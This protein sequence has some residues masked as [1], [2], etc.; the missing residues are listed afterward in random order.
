MRGTAMP[1][2]SRQRTSGNCVLLANSRGSE[3][4]REVTWVILYEV[5]T[6]RNS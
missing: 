2:S 3:L 1:T 4:L 5:H 6:M